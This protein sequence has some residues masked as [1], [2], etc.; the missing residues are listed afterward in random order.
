MMVE[1]LP[2]MFVYGT[3]TAVLFF[4]IDMTMY[5]CV[6]RMRPVSMTEVW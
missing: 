4:V 5:W 1:V 2:W 3:V 6:G